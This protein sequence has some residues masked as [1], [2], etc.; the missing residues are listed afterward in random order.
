MLM[1]KLLLVTG[2]LAAPMFACGAEDDSSGELGATTD[3]DAAETPYYGCWKYGLYSAN[4][5]NG[6]YSSP[7]PWVSV[8]NSGP[9]GWRQ[10][11]V[12][13]RSTEH[14]YSV[15]LLTDFTGARTSTGGRARF[16]C[17]DVSAGTYYLVYSPWY[18]NGDGNGTVVELD[19]VQ[20]PGGCADF[21]NDYVTYGN[22][23]NHYAT[24]L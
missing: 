2:M 4:T 11:K 15:E 3:E 1:H 12:R 22:A 14:P 8:S 13:E 16:T 7:G 20:N 6:T 24:C 21:P 23:N 9:Y 19:V 10:T 17:R 18:T 5:S